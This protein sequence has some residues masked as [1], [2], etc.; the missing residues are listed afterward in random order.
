MQEYVAK[1]SYVIEVTDHSI[2]QIY[3]FWPTLAAQSYRKQ[4][5]TDNVET[6]MSTAKRS[7]KPT[8][9]KA[10]THCA[11]IILVI[12]N[13]PFLASSINCA[14]LRYHFK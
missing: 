5:L 3:F 7:S 14:K 11:R 10:C 1:E 4:M 2:F 9:N 12:A 6:G 13:R 8:S